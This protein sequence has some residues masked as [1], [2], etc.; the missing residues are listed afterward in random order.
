[1]AASMRGNVFIDGRNLL[2]GDAARRAGLVYEGIGRGFSPQAD[3]AP[4]A[5]TF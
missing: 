2:D 3:L 1:V 5:S 4:T